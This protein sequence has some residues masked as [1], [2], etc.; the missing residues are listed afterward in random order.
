MVYFDNGHLH[1]AEKT[2]SAKTQMQFTPIFG[3]CSL[4]KPTAYKNFIESVLEGKV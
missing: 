4:K 3:V 2:D 1:L